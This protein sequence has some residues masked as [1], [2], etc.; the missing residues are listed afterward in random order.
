VNIEQARTHLPK[1]YKISD[2]ELTK[3]LAEDYAIANLAV[4]EVLSGRYQKN[5]KV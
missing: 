2:E 4:E 1:G 5:K 3:L